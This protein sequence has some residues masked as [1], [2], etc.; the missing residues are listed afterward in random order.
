[1]RRQAK[2]RRLRSEISAIDTKRLRL[3]HDTACYL[4]CEPNAITFRGRS[5]EKPVG[6]LFAL[7]SGCRQD[8]G[9]CSRTPAGGFSLAAASARGS[10]LFVATEIFMKVDGD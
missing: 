8:V 5:Q 7:F 10:K 3:K 6:R 2:N 1:V 4:A 9:I